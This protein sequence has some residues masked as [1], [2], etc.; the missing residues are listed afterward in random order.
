MVGE[1]FGLKDLFFIP[2]GNF[3]QD[4]FVQGHFSWGVL[5]GEGGR[6]DSET[7]Y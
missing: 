4:R 3:A 2:L 5:L 6:G 7:L 1:D